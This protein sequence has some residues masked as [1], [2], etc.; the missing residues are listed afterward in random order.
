[1]KKKMYEKPTT[2]IVKTEVLSHILQG[3]PYSMETTGRR[4]QLEDDTESLGW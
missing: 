1:M 2:E 4:N 3:S